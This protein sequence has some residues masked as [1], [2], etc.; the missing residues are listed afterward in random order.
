MEDGEIVALLQP[1]MKDPVASP[2]S[3]DRLLLTQFFDHQLGAGS[4]QYPIVHVTGT[5][6]K[7]S[8]VCKIAKACQLAGCTV[9]VF[10]SPH[11]YTI[12]ERIQINEELISA[13]DLMGYAQQVLALTH[14]YQVE[15]HFFEIMTLIA[16]RY[17]ADRKVDLVVLEVGIGG[18]HDST[19]FITPILSIITSISYDH[20]QILGS[21]LEAIAMHKAGIIKPHVPVVLGPSAHHK[22]IIEKARLKKA[23]VIFSQEVGACFDEEN[24]AVAQHA[25]HYLM[26]YFPLSEG[27]IYR[28]LQAMPPCRFE[29]MTLPDISQMPA[30]IV[31]DVAHNPG[32]FTKLLEAIRTRFGTQRARFMVGMSKG[33]EIERS[34]Q[35][36]SSYAQYIYL[37]PVASHKLL[38]PKELGKQLH[39][40]GYSAYGCRNSLEET[41]RLALA[42][43][44]EHGDLLVVCGS[45]YIMAEIKKLLK[46]LI[47]QKTG[48]VVLEEVDSAAPHG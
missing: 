28:G 4:K 2:T 14:Q 11:L 9:G 32:G 42:E 10:S 37:A 44:A 6:G 47:Q 17:F 21:T 40:L 25:L 5:N 24:S 29:V 22:V 19:N 3:I 31:F 46:V 1:F 18:L 48:V 26:S 38:P 45:F 23:A 27:C 16:L 35:V 20:T 30:S 12:R 39:A 15:L 8:V 36:L 43:S 7:G 13:E 41:F 33:K 34:M